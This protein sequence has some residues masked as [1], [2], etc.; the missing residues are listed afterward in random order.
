MSTH[1]TSCL[2]ASCYTLQTLAKTKA[3]A[4]SQHA[5]GVLKLALVSLAA[6]S[7]AFVVVLV[8]GIMTLSIFLDPHRA[9][10]K[11]ILSVGGRV[12]DKDSNYLILE[13]QMCSV[14]DCHVIMTR[15]VRLKRQA[16]D[17]DVQEGD[18]VT[19]RINGEEQSPVFFDSQ[20][21]PGVSYR[22]LFDHD[23]I[24]PGIKQ[25]WMH[26]AIYILALGAALLTAW[27]WLKVRLI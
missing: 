2:I 12:I 3:K 14:A 4:S 6:G 7:V 19:V 13:R 18:L 21:E 15:E 8:F 22:I 16:I 17:D 20:V 26:A 10:K 9:I 5:V 1:T 24:E 11:G 27:A 25:P 23:R